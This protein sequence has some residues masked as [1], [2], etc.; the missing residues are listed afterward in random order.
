MSDQVQL[1]DDEIVMR[2][3]PGGP[4]WQVPPDG[5]IASPN[6][7]L[8]PNEAGISVSRLSV[9][10]AQKLM[11]LRGNPE[12][13]SHI[14]SARVGDICSFGYMVVADPTDDDPGHALI[15]PTTARI[16]T[17]AEQRR[18]AQLF[19]YVDS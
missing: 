10:S 11:E 2:H 13:G 5:R 15:V 7:R 16:E 19:R 18:L 3:I 8:K 17:K 9:T 4:S 6:F 12:S 14:A 1:S